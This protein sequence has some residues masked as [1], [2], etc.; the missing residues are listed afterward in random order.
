[1]ILYTIATAKFFETKV[2]FPFLNDR[3]QKVGTLWI[4]LFLTEE[5]K[6]EIN[7]VFPDRVVNY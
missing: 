5:E 7:M 3:L 6:N 4:D 2:L 1:M